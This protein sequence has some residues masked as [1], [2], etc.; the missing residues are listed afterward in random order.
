MP[1]GQFHFKGTSGVRYAL[2][3][4]PT[5]ACIMSSSPGFRKYLSGIV[6]EDMCRSNY[7]Q[8]SIIV[9]LELSRYP[10]ILKGK[11]IFFI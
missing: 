2:P 3:A 7:V 10:G 6:T 5:D 1:F 9:S 11:S 4:M 8:F